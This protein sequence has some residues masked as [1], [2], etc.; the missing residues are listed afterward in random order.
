MLG[1][2]LNGLWAVY[3]GNF[4]ARTE[5]RASGREIRQNAEGYQH[6]IGQGCFWKRLDSVGRELEVG[7]SEFGD[8][9][10]IGGGFVC[11]WLDGD[12]GFMRRWLP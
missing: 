11:V 1:F 12:S 2:G 5:L 3:H 4:A 7:R 6:K 8:F 10:T 9:Q